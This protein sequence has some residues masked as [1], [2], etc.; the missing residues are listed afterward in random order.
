MEEIEIKDKGD[1]CKRKRIYD[2]I[3]ISKRFADI[4]VLSL[5]ILLMFFIIAAI[6]SAGN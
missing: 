1:N 2:G 3:K 5:S 6:F 4:I